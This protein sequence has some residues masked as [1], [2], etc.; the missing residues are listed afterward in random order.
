MNTNFVT[1]IKRI[2]AEQGEA[3]LANPQRVKG[4]V[5]DYAARESKVER[6]AFG[7]CI[8]YGAYTEMKSAPSAAARQMVKAAVV[9]KVHSNEGMDIALCNGAMDV[10]E[11]AMFG[12]DAS[13]NGNQ[14]PQAPLASYSPPLAQ[15]YQLPQY[16]QP[17]TPQKIED[18]EWDDIKIALTIAVVIVVSMILLYLAM[19]VV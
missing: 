10:L 9:Q 17:Q 12:V 16:T 15:Q 18:N 3:I 5:Q 2:I 13:T 4:L 14:P 7:R 1:V 19:L 6:L 11:A 8:E